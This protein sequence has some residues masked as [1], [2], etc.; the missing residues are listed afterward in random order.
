M[1][2]VCLGLNSTAARNASDDNCIGTR[3]PEVGLHLWVPLGSIAAG[4][5]RAAIWIRLRVY[6]GWP[7][8]PVSDKGSAAEQSAANAS[9]YHLCPG[10]PT[11]RAPESLLSQ[12]TRGRNDQ[13]VGL[14]NRLSLREQ[15][16]ISHPSAE[17]LFNTRSLWTFSFLGVGALEL[18]PSSDHSATS[19]SSLLVVHLIVVRAGSGKPL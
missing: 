18:S 17:S 16:I 8:R 14:N 19:I 3:R 2:N 1:A 4:Q 5:V 10:S 13:P 7:N 11:A 6:C 15:S 12:P 9:R